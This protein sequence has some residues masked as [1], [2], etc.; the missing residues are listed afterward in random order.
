MVTRLVGHKGLDLVTAIGGELMQED[1]QLAV[2]GAGESG[3]EDYFRWLCGAHGGKAAV[4]LGYDAHLAQEL[5]AGSDLFLMPSRSEPC[6]L[7]QMIAMRYGSLPIVRETGGLKDTVT[8]YNQFTGTGRGFVF[9]DI[10]AND[11]LWVIREA[12]E[13]YFSSKTAWRGLQK[14]GMTAD[15]SWTNSAKQYLDIYQRIQD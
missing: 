2:L 1:V 4:Y 13:L 9:S 6:G 8:P 10:N 14:A 11:M 5:Y 3:Y 15:F 12:V 7:S